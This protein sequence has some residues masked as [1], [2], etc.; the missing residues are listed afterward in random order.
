MKTFKNVDIGFSI[1]L[2][3]SFAILT[4]L[5]R[6][7]IFIGGYFAVG[8]WQLVSMVV[9][10]AKGWFTSKGSARYIYHRIVATLFCLTA[11]GCVV[12]PLLWIIMYFMLFAAPV[13]AI[14]YTV[15]CRNEYVLLKNRALIQMK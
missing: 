14:I 6:D 11:L 13:M 10:T 3:L 9:H 2:I 5:R 8:A 4:A 12:F 15:I 1:G 7:L